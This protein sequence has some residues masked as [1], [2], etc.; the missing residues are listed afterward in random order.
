LSGA[1]SMRAMVSVEP[2]AGNGTTTV[3][4]FC[5]Q[6]ALAA[7]AAVLSAVPAASANA[8]PAPR[9][10]RAE[11]RGAMRADEVKIVVS[12]LDKSCV[13]QPAGIRRHPGRRPMALPDHAG[14]LVIEF[15][16]RDQE[17]HRDRVIARAQALLLI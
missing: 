12:C 14:R 11:S 2:P 17:L 8:T 10:S 9:R 16:V 7:S 13:P 15:P 6:F 4:A 5:G 1:A 3:T